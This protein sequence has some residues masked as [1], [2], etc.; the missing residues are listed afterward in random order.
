MLLLLF[1]LLLLYIMDILSRPS[2]IEEIAEQAFV[3][4]A[5]L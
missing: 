4:G 1:L 5:L 2:P 3:P